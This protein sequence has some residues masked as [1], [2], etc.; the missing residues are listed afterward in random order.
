MII[1]TVDTAE[2]SPS[3]F[4]PVILVAEDEVL[5]RN[6]VC[7]QLQREGYHV[8]AASDGQEA[9]DLSRAYTGRIQLLLTDV[10]MPKMNGL[11]LAERLLN[12]RPG[13]RVLV[14]SGMLSPG[15]TGSITLPFLRKPFVARD[16]REKIHAVLKAPP[17]PQPKS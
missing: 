6:F 12:E 10:K 2:Q 11:S 4:Q 13:L 3:L 7:L 15:Q 14:M 8:L 16:L 1:L 9:L 17:P 5:I